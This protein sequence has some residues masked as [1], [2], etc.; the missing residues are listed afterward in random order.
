MSYIQ[1]SSIPTHVGDMQDTHAASYQGQFEALDMAAGPID[2]DFILPEN[3]YDATNTARSKLFSSTPG[4]NHQERFSL[5]PSLP[6]GTIDT[7]IV[8]RVGSPP[9]ADDVPDMAWSGDSVSTSSGSFEQSYA[10]H[11]AAARP[12]LESSVNTLVDRFCGLNVAPKS[13]WYLELEMGEIEDTHITYCDVPGYN[14]DEIVA[15]TLQYNPTDADRALLNAPYLGCCE[16]PSDDEDDGGDE[17]MFD[18]RD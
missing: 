7:H 12:R 17:Y 18:V 10:A 13:A 9:P 5:H 16:L 4:I 15:D 6:Q 2:E 3:V 14:R 11:Y 8:G 1:R